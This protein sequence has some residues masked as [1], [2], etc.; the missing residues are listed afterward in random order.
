MTEKTWTR[1]EVEKILDEAVS[2][3]VARFTGRPEWASPHGMLRP[4]RHAAWVDGWERADRALKAHRD[5]LRAAVR[6]AP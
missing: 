2:G 4:G 6:R 1:G 3:A 5:A